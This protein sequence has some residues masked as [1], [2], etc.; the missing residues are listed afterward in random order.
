MAAEIN[1]V[2]SAELDLHC[3]LF[4][5]DRILPS[6]PLRDGIA[7]LQGG[8]CFYC[9]GPPG[10]TPE[11]GH[12]IVRV[13]CGIDAVENLVLADL[14]CNNDK[15]DLLPGPQRPYAN[16]GQTAKRSRGP[17]TGEPSG[18]PS[19]ADVRPRGAH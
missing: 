19:S 3:H 5:S 8:R 1:G 6:R 10:A 17:D 11:A 15:R 13:R 16:D 14:R 18:E 12:F 7:A 4:G 9:H 2:A